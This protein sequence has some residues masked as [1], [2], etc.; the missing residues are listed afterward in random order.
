MSQTSSLYFDLES[1]VFLVQDPLDKFDESV[2]IK[3]LA[4]YTS[5]QS[6][7][8]FDFPDDSDC[9]S[10]GSHLGDCI[11]HILLFRGKIDS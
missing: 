9:L 10:N 7:D 3:L 11:D 8:R 2:M 6:Y 4:R 5:K 1:L